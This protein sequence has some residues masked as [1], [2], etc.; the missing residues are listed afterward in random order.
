MIIPGYYV[1]NSCIFRMRSFKVPEESVGSLLGQGCQNMKDI[2]VKTGAR[3]NIKRKFEEPLATVYILGGDESLAEALV[4][5]AVKHF[6]AARCPLK[7]E[8]F[9]NVTESEIVAYDLRCLMSQMKF[10]CNN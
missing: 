7:K 5:M 3:V 10:G 4:I 2:M 1:L 9:C 8:D 6:L